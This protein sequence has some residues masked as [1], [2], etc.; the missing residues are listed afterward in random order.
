MAKSISVPITGNA[1]PLRKALVAA[2]NDLNTFGSRAAASAKK[3]SLALGT[4]GAA[5]ALVAVKWAKMAEQAQIADKRIERV[6]MSMGVF[7]VQTSKVTARLQKYGDALERQIGVEAET[8]KLVQAKLLT[9]RQLAMTADT[10]GAAF[11]RATLAAFDMASAG[12]GSAE[13]NAVQLGKALEDPIKGVNSLRRS[14]ITFT[15]SEKNKLK[16]LVESNRVHE[17]QRVILDAIETQVKGTASVTATATTRMKLAFGEVTDALTTALLPYMNRI[18]DSMRDIG[19]QATLNGLGAS[20]KQ[21]GEEFKDASYNMDGTVNGLGRFLNGVT[22]TANGV[23]RLLNATAAFGRVTR[24]ADVENLKLNTTLGTLTDSQRKAKLA[25]DGYVETLSGLILYAG[26]AVTTQE[27]LN[28]YMGPVAS[29]NIIDLIAYRKQYIQSLKEQAAAE[30]RA[31]AARDK[32]KQKTKEMKDALTSAKEA[33]RAYVASIR[34]SITSSVNL[35]TA[36]TDA[37][38]QQKDA[39]DALSDALKDRA[40][41]YAALNTAKAASDA[42]A[43]ADALA[44]VAAAETA[45]TD[46]Q[47]AKPKSYSEIFREQITAAKTFAG[48]LKTLIAAPYK[49][50]TAAVQQILA[51]GP[52]AGAQVTSDMIAGTAG[53]TAG[54][55]NTSLQQVAD[56]GTAAGMATPGISAILSGKLTGTTQN[57][58]SITVQAGVGDKLEIAKEVVELLKVYEKRLGAVPVKVK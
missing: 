16:V 49:L 11:D 10:A 53:L 52:V 25:A 23:K 39:A 4:A 21:V 35:S 2:G 1:A 33:A 28:H 19:E 57:T 58:Y 14:G 15:E 20:V 29:R 55:L 6:A 50:S 51:L 12:F 13:Q 26:K 42:G 17:A 47:A 36:F 31:T 30:D 37:T 48:N 5:G 9:F 44:R 27:Q 22:H 56:A 7:G 43:Y 24:L 46:A 38:T 8:I 40:D 34:D 3:A 45:V 32:Q 54:E 18:A 41:A